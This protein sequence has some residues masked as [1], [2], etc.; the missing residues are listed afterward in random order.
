MYFS[1]L[2]F[3]QFNIILHMTG[4]SSR[5]TFFSLGL[6]SHLIMLMGSSWLCPQALLLVML[7]GLY[8]ILAIELT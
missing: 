3:Q 5:H 6:G 8:G 4:K 1:S 7:R 2:H